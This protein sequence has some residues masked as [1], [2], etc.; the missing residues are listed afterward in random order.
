MHSRNL[1]VFFPRPGSITTSSIAEDGS[2]EVQL[3][4]DEEAP[5][6]PS[7]G[8][9]V[10]VPGSRRGPVTPLG[11]GFTFGARPPSNLPTPEFIAAP[12]SASS[13]SKRGHHHKH[14]LSH[15][16]FS[17][18]EPGGG[19]PLMNEDQ[20]HTQPTPTPIS[21]WGPM[22]AFPETA[23]SSQ[24][25]FKLPPSN[26]H[27][28]LWQ[29]QPTEIS[30]AAL[31]SSVGQFVLGSYMWVMG[32]QVGSLSVTGLGYWVVFDSFGV[33]LSGVVPGWLASGSKGG[34]GEKERVRRPYGYV[35]FCLGIQVADVFRRSNG[36][37]ETVL[38]F[39]QAVYLMFSS[40]Y[41]CKE[42]VEHLLLSAGG[43]EGHHHHHGDEDEGV[44]YVGILAIYSA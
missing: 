28:D 7:A 44:G 39:A 40:V 35:V 13:A 25:G 9:S 11:Q 21:P 15:N 6:M 26:G 19:S 23:A 33:A 41:V 17:F 4:I 30:T 29:A 18:L 27:T 2:Q 10:S 38:M 43:G 1:S 24:S 34:S 14:S 32:Q 20:L 3:V 12:R 5:L 31:S 16:F 37:V 42:T 36:R 8:S 22:S